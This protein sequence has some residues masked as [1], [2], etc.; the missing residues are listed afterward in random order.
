MPG[1][2]LDT[3]ERKQEKEMIIVLT[4]FTNLHQGSKCICTEISF[5]T[6]KTLIKVTIKQISFWKNTKMLCK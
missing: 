6:N 3:V 1:A 5:L 2:G 4:E